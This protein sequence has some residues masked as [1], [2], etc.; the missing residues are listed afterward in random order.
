MEEHANL[1]RAA[2]ALYECTGEDRFRK[3]AESFVNK[4]KQHYKDENDAYF[5]AANDTSNLI[6]HTKTVSDD[7]TPSGNGSL[8]GVLAR[9]YYLIGAEQNRALAD[10]IVRAFAGEF[11]PRRGSL[12]DNKN[13]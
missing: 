5:F 11:P 9:F 2:I 6:T 7:A 10:N 13:A 3:D 8:A 4:C 1:A 12:N